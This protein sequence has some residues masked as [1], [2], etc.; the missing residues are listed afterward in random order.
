VR[1]RWIAGPIVATALAIL[2]GRLVP[3]SAQEGKKA[4]APAPAPAPAGSPTCADCHEEETAQWKV[5]GHSRAMKPE[6]LAEW[7]RQGKKWECLVCHTSR[8]DRNTG[9]FSKEGVGCES[10]H[11]AAKPDHPNSQKMA[12]PVTSE[13]CRDCH[14]LTY[15]E[16][17]V[18]AHGQKDIGCTSCHAMHA[19]QLRKEDPDQMCGSCHTER[20]R[21]FAHA[22]H[23]V[24]GLHCISCH[25]P[26]PPAGRSKIRGTGAR[27]HSYGVGAETCASCHRVQVHQSGEMTALETEVK[28]LRGAG[29]EETLMEIPALRKDNARLQKAF[30]DDREVMPW[31]VGLSFLLGLGL[32]VGFMRLSRRPPAEET[33]GS[34]E[35]GASKAP[36]EGAAKVPAGDRA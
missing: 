23:R 25:M 21:D 31:V 5:S 34:P 36:A 22:T 3:A 8:Y 13:A 17:R 24:K 27:G 9:D 10:C 28:T 12:M 11:G 4:G 16:W 15:G 33:A 6:F 18:S 20:L 26:N 30:D 2:A 7:E 29:A 19:M 32:G 1:T 35:K 14:S